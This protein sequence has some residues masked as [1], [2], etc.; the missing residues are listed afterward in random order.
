M[1]AKGEVEPESEGLLD[2]SCRN[3]K[4][5]PKLLCTT[6]CGLAN[7]KDAKK[8]SYLIRTQPVADKVRARC[9]VKTKHT[10]QLVCA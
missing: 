2:E 5:P 6:L 10:L 8:E 4:S 9:Y 7:D 3:S 1:K